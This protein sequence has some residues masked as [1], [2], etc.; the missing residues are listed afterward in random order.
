LHCSKTLLVKGPDNRKRDSTTT[1]SNAAKGKGVA[2]RAVRPQEIVRVWR[3]Y[4]QWVADQTLEDYAL[5]FT[6]DSARR[7]LQ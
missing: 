7:C 6:A 1:Q 4:N 5:R 2:P 3:Q